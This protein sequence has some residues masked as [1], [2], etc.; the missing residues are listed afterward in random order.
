MNEK[1]LLQE[2][3]KKRGNLTLSE[4]LIKVEIM[5]ENHLAHHE[6]LTK[7]L[8]YPILVGV[9][10]SVILSILTLVFKSGLVK[11]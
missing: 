11:I 4:R 10:I 1:N 5:L 6:K 3:L 7:C 9:G 8:L 2:E